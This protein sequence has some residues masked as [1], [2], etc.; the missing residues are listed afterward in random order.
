[1]GVMSAMLGA[2]RPRVREIARS[3]PFHRA[4]ARQFGQHEHQIDQEL[5]QIA[6]ERPAQFD[7]HAGEAPAPFL[8]EAKGVLGQHFVRPAALRCRPR[9]AALQRKCSCRPA[10]QQNR[11]APR[12]VGVNR[13]NSS[14]WAS[15]DAWSR[16]TATNVC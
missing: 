10:K 1:M 9:R 8:E 15:P 4:P 12:A 5:V 7:Q 13:H 3:A 16:L 2:F 14:T 6:V 11:N